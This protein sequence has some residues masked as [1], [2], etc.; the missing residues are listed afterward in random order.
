MTR[1]VLPPRPAAMAAY[2]TILRRPQLVPRLHVEP[3]LRPDTEAALQAQCRV[4]S[5]RPLTVDDLID[6]T[7]GHT[8]RHGEPVPRLRLRQLIQGCAAAH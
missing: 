6:P 1:P 2:G 3:E 4:S 7:R 8:D 5:D